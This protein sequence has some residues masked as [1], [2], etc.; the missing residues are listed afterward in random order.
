M[1]ERDVS[2]W[3]L[4]AAALRGFIL[5]HAVNPAEA[6]QNVNQKTTKKRID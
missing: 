1:D 5:C 6:S 4:A 3:I 2:I